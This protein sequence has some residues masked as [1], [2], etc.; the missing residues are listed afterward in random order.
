MKSVIKNFCQSK[1]NGLFLLDMPTGFG[2]TYNVVE[3]IYENYD[4]LQGKIFFIT[5]SKKNL[6]REELRQ[7]FE[8]NGKLK[9]YDENV[10]FI[11]SNCNSLIDNWDDVKSYIPEKF[12]NNI[13]NN[14]DKNIKIFE[15]FKNSHDEDIKNNILEK[16]KDLDKEFRDFIEN[17]LKQNFNT[18]KKRKEKIKYDKEYSWI[19]KLYPAVF[20]SDKKVIITSLDKFLLKNST[21]IQPSYKFLSSDIINNSII[22]IDEFDTSKERILN[23]IIEDGLK[24]KIDYI[25]LFNIIYS[26]LNTRVLPKELLKDSKNQ[27]EKIKK[28]NTKS[29]KNIFNNLKKISKEIFDEFNL[30]FNYKTRGTINDRNF[31]F[32]DY[33]YHSILRNNKKFINITYDK[34]SRIN[35]IDFLDKKETEDSK[36]IIALLRKLNGFISYFQKACRIIGENYYHLQIENNNNLSDDITYESSIKTVLSNFILDEKYQNYMFEKILFNERM[37]KMDSINYKQFDNSIYE[38]GFRYYDFID[39]LNHNMESKIMLYS[40]N[41]SPEKILLNLCNKSKVIGVSATATI[42]TVLG[43]YDIDYLKDNLKD[44]FYNMSDN[45]K[46][47]LKDKFKNHI[48][49][50]KNNIDIKVDSIEASE[51]EN[52][53]KDIFGEEYCGD[54]KLAIERECDNE[55]PKKRYIRIFKIFKEFLIKN[56]IKSFLYLTNKFPREKDAEFNLIHIREAFEYLIK[57]TL[58]KEDN[59]DEYVVI[60]ETKD[61]EEKKKKFLKELSEGKKKFIISTYQTM[62]A[63]QNIQ[64][65]VPKDIENILIPINDDIERN[66]NCKKKD[67]DAIYLDK[68][69][70]LIVNISNKKIKEE[71]FIK[72]I[73]QIEFLKEKGEISNK[74]A[75]SKIK[76]AFIHLTS[77]NYKSIK[78]EYNTDSAKYY[79]IKILIQAVG[80]ICRT[81]L[82]N[83]NVYIYL[84]DEIIDYL[85]DITLENDR[86][87]NPEF[88]AV[89]KKIN[90]Y[91]T[92]LENKKKKNK[93][94]L[95]LAENISGKAN[96]KIQDFLSN[97]WTK[98]SMKMWKN[99]RMDVLKYPTLSREEIKERLYLKNLYFEIPNKSNSYTYNQEE[100]YNNIEISFENDFNQTV[101]EKDARLDVLMEIE[102]L[103]EYFREMGFATEF[104]NNEYIMSPV[105]FNNIYKGA[106]GEEVGKFVLKKYFNKDLKEIEDSNYFELFDFEIGNGIYVDFKHW[107]EI[108]HIDATQEKEKIMKKLKTCNGKRALIINILAES[109]SKKIVSSSNGKII[110]IPFLYD[111]TNKEIS[112]YILKEIQSKGYLENED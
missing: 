10:L 17:D 57:M 44:R 53:I 89:L 54:F 8:Q 3:Y 65:E 51:W 39:D 6:P 61:F 49:N 100:D 99:L 4:K 111:F 1:E 27:K 106:L 21:L 18:P 74:E 93:K 59:F 58:N 42:N 75:I 80:R 11:D 45:E 101:S 60:V 46:L 67:F 78:G 12:R 14:I 30:E 112:R 83:K 22:F 92:S 29:I 66:I 68:P 84:S 41:N 62:G 20:T 94:F 77:F 63:G 108:T 43:N 23:R 47:L 55:Y 73:Y 26:Q 72:Y 79:S 2:K 104:K 98:E 33:R 7:K 107:K 69:T 85:N 15:R 70:N 95:N 52:D 86:L 76:E 16:L 34:I 9:E 82:K 64:Y 5:A 96:D 81:N 90:S 109:K 32:S 50:Y 48:K 28:D 35:W 13:Y 97:E 88:K 25:K 87:L 102:E 110:E 105:I 56:D 103:R 37:K 71:D 91:K 38:D 24:E 36:S 31:L 19:G 40:F